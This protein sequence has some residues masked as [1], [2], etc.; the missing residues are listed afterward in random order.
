MKPLKM[1]FL[2]WF[3]IFCL[4]YVF[5]S[6]G[7]YEHGRIVFYSSMFP[8]DEE[9]SY[10]DALALIRKHGLN[11]SVPQVI[12]GNF[13]LRGVYV[14]PSYSPRQVFFLYADEHIY[15]LRFE[16]LLPGFSG[17]PDFTIWVDLTWRHNPRVFRLTTEFNLICFYIRCLPAFL[18]K[19]GWAGK[20]YID[21]WPSWC[22]E[23]YEVHIFRGPTHDI[24]H[25]VWSQII[26]FTPNG[27]VY[28][29][30]AFKLDDLTFVA[31]GLNCT[32]VGG[33]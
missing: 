9:I 19:G 4:Y 5:D 32:I 11:I 16:Y 30:S 12:F 21:G 28:L 33:G 15:V 7:F 25:G 27:A 14:W 24:Y 8:L 18:L 10:D 20:R 1:I 23:V 26:I 6:I 13:S 22:T 2:I 29:Q 3:V 31:D 17:E